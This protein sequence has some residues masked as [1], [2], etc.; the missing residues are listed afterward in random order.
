MSEKKKLRKSA[1]KAEEQRRW[2][3]WLR[4]SGSLLLSIGLPNEILADQEHWTDFC[5]HARL[6]MYPSTTKF[7]VGD[8]KTTEGRRLMNFLNDLLTPEEKA[9]SA[10]FRR[11]RERFDVASPN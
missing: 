11:L 2:D 4:T 5:T 7:T 10:L 3:E 9:Y 1:H 6:H 8:I